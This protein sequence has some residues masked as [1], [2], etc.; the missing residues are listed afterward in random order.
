MSHPMLDV[1]DALCVT[2][3][4]QAVQPLHGCEYHNDDRFKHG[5]RLIREFAAAS[6]LGK[7]ERRLTV[8]EAADVLRLMHN[9]EPASADERVFDGSKVHCG[10]CQ[11][12]SWVERSLLS[13]RKRK[14][15]P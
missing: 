7:D 2:S 10:Y 8:N 3:F 13:A 4:L 14:A 12:L 6:L 9:I 15:S 1:E 5:D 11:I